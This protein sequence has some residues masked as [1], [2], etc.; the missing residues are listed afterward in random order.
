MP[1][2]PTSTSSP[3]PP[4]SGVDDDGVDGAVANTAAGRARQVELDVRHAGSRQVI[5][6]GGICA[7]TLSHVDLFD[8]FDIHDDIGH[9]AEEPQTGAVSGQIEVLADVGTVELHRVGASPT[10]DG[11][12]TIQA[13][14]VGY[15]HWAVGG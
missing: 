15:D 13:G 11:M 1:A 10:F 7:T 9:V 3:S 2:P 8:T 4:T 6:G 14:G 12:D 5:D